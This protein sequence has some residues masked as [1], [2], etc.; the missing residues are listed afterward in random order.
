[1]E[2]IKRCILA[3][4]MPFSYLFYKLYAFYLVM[5][6][7]DT[8]SGMS[9]LGVMGGLIACNVITLYLT[10]WGCFPPIWIYA[11]SFLIIIPYAFPKVAEKIVSKYENEKVNSRIIGNIVVVIYIFSSIISLILVL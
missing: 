1:V 4:L 10:I 8:P 7:G 9:H 6:S 2:C 11:I 3:I 5:S